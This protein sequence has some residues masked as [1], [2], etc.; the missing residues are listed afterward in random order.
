L[1]S[2]HDARPQ[3]RG[4]AS[5]IRFFSGQ[6][7]HVN[8]TWNQ[9]LNINIHEKQ[10]D[11]LFPVGTNIYW[12]I[13]KAMYKSHYLTKLE[14]FDE[15]QPLERKLDETSV[16]ETQAQFSHATPGKPNPRCTNTEEFTVDFYKAKYSRWRPWVTPIRK[17]REQ[18][19]EHS[20]LAK[21]KRER[22]EPVDLT[23]VIDYPFGEESCSMRRARMNSEWQRQAISEHNTHRP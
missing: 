4:E 14:E 3:K 21:R 1:N 23:H 6:R 20:D 19:K 17:L 7:G 5:S 10:T 8:I 2:I 16:K 18:A 12:Q 11:N 15:Y 13:Y 22:E 9:R